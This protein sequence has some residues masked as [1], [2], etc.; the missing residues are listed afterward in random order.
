MISLLKSKV[1]RQNQGFPQKIMQIE[2]KLR[3]FGAK[4]AN[5]RQIEANLRQ[6]W[7]NHSQI[8]ENV[9]WPYLGAE[10]NWAQPI[11]RMRQIG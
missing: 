11:S 6:R 2:A 5:W 1:L 7:P 8:E 10:A 9:P 3:K 4:S